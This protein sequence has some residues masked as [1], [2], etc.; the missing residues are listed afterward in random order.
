MCIALA[1]IAMGRGELTDASAWVRDALHSPEINDQIT[2][3]KQVLNELK[4][5][6]Q[7]QDEAEEWGLY[8]DSLRSEH[9]DGGLVGQLIASLARPTEDS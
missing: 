2:V 6:F 1:R 5:A 3:V 9:A 4:G 7:K 8:I